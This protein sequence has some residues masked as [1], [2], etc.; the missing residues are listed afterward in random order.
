MATHTAETIER[1]ELGFGFHPESMTRVHWLLAGLAAITGVVHLYLYLAQGFLP[2]LLAGVV[3]FA[4]IAGMLVI[5][6]GHVA[7]RAIYAL[8]V[9]FTAA[10]IA[11]WV[12]L[13]MPDFA[14][15]VFDKVVQIA[16][17][18][19]LIYLFRMEMQR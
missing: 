14:L 3:F 19:L 11:A 12:A 13:G 1:T 9:P 5:P 6:Y 17:I 16:L 10:Q 7:R 15:G 18:V 4:A 8:G 2:F